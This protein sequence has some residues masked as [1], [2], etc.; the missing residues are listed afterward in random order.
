MPHLQIFLNLDIT[1]VDALVVMVMS[2]GMKFG[3]KIVYNLVIRRLPL[4]HQYSF[5]E[6][7]FLM[8]MIGLFTDELLITFFN[9]FESPKRLIGTL[10]NLQFLLL[11][12]FSALYLWKLKKVKANGKKVRETKLEYLGVLMISKNL[13]FMRYLFVIDVVTLLIL[14]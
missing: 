7:R 9:I 5:S 14:N 12:F 11:L 6:I 4:L 1:W 8:T 13:I 3:W 10:P 2:V